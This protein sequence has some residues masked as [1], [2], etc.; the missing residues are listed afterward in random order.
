MQWDVVDPVL[1]AAGDYYIYA[2]TTDASQF[3]V[4]RSSKKVAVRHSP[5]LRLDVL[6]D[7]VLSGADT[8]V[9]GGLHPQ[10][11]VSITWGRSGR[12]GDRDVD[13]NAQISLYYST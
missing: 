11:F 8:I 4:G 5:F 2:V 7:Q 6:N 3:Q 1:V 13:D 9:T 10:Q 12:D